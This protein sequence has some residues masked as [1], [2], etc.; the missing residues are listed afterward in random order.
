MPT[1]RIQPFKSR[2]VE[3]SDQTIYN[4][5]FVRKFEVPVAYTRTIPNPIHN[6]I[7]VTNVHPLQ[8]RHLMIL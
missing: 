4:G 2:S 6:Q 7:G 8:N 1:K 3:L 5:I